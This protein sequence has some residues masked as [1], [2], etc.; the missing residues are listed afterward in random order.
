M[1][2]VVLGMSLWASP[3]LN[4]DAVL[5]GVVPQ[6]HMDGLFGQQPEQCTFTRAARLKASMTAVFRPSTPPAAVFP[7][8]ESTVATWSLMAMRLAARPKVL[9]FA[10]AWM[11]LFSS[12]QV[13]R[14]MS[15]HTALP[16]VP[17]RSRF[18][19]RNG[20]GIGEVLHHF[21]R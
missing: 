13:P 14:M 11:T 16:T 5:L 12:C 8:H 15:P 9:N 7:L 10:S 1:A 17:R 2:V 6:R 4:D 3:G 21:I 18:R 19:S 20:L